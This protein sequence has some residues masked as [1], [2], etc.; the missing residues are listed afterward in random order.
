M[1]R[2]ELRLEL[3]KLTYAHGRDAAEAVGRAK[4]LEEYIS[5]DAAPSDSAK[6]Q[7]VSK[8]DEKSSKKSGN[9]DIL[10]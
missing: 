2:D 6:P 5:Q 4:T 1:Q 9:P 3:L 7:S 10:S 8:R